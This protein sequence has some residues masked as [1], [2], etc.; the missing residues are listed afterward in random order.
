[1]TVYSTGIKR[2]RSEINKSH[3]IILTNTKDEKI[4][5]RILN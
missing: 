2:L 5:H 4:K 3:L 1:L